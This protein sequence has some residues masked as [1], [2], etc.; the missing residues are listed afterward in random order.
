MRNPHHK[1][2]DNICGITFPVDERTLTAYQNPLHLKLQTTYKECLNTILSSAS[3]DA[4]IVIVIVV[5]IVLGINGPYGES[6][7]TMS[8]GVEVTSRDCN[9]LL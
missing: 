9:Y 2:N 7:R 5:F 4:N 6:E 1:Y 3:E 8:Q